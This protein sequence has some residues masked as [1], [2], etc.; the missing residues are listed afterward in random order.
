[1]FRKLKYPSII[2]AG[3]LIFFVGVMIIIQKDRHQ[4]GFFGA[5]HTVVLRADGFEPKKIS[6]KKGDMVT[7]TTQTQVP[8]W[9]ASNLHPTHF[10]YPEFDPKEPIAPGK[11]WSFVFYKVGMWRYHDHLNPSLTGTIEVHE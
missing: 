9:P 4:G 5:K 8:F 3:I 10:I 11:Q 6:I 7:F 2:L 1:M